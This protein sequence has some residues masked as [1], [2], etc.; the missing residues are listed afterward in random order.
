MKVIEK[1][2]KWAHGLS[3]RWGQPPHIV[4]H[5]SAS[6]LNTT[7]E[8][9]HRWHLKA[10]YSGIGYHYVIDPY[11]RIY[12]GRLEWAI[13]AHAKGGNTSIGIC[14]IGNFDKPGSMPGAQVRAGQEL[15]AYLYGKYPAATP[16]RHADVIG[17]STACPGRYFPWV[18]ITKRSPVTKKVKPIPLSDRSITVPRQKKPNRAGWW[19]LHLRP[20]IE[21]VR[22]Q[23]D[24]DR[25][26]AGSADPLVIPLPRKQPKWMKKMW[27]WKKSKR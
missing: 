3:Q 14:F 11:G 2:Y 4:I 20:Y 1:Q 24:A 18:E 21:K 5:H 10:G 17:S 19:N 15:M 16:R 8:D 9:I 13:G 7:P 12:R 27:A 25:V 23:G 6:S 22:K 26:K